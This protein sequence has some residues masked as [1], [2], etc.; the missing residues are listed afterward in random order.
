MNNWQSSGQ[1]SNR[2]VSQ[3]ITQL[4]KGKYRLTVYRMSAGENAFLFANDEVQSLGS[5]GE[6]GEDVSLDFELN[7]TADVYIGIKLIG[8]TANN[9]KFDNFRLT[10]LG[11]TTSGPGTN[12]APIQVSSTANSEIYNLLGQKL[13]KLQKGINIVHG[14]KIYLK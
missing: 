7:E 3:T 13:L 11:N 6:T 1:L 10:Y 4:P 14:K 5:N 9:L 8:F 12:I 2:S